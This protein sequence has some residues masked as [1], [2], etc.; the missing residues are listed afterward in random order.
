MCKRKERSTDFHTP[1][2]NADEFRRFYEVKLET[3]LFQMQKLTQQPG[4]G[5]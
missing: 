2:K 4:A 1:V 5:F 3:A